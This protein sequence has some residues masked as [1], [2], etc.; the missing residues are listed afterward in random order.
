MR[1]LI[2]WLLAFAVVFTV[3]LGAEVSLV[4]LRLSPPAAYVLYRA[5]RV[6]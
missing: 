4:F 1:W 3:W 2:L 5:W 6:E